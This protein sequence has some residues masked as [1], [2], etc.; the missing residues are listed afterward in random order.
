MISCLTQLTRARSFFKPPCP[1]AALHTSL[2]PTP[3]ARQQGS[4][5]SRCQTCAPSHARA[6]LAAPHR[7]PELDGR[8]PRVSVDEPVAEPVA[9]VG[10]PDRLAIAVSL[11]A[12]GTR[13]RRG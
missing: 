4:A 1:D 6:L 9:G 10:A 5:T 7:A 13:A 3:L 8:P 11:V 12:G 2:R